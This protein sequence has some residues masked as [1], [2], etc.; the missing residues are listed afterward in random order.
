MNDN[1]LIN[2][3]I[4]IYTNLQ[5][6]QNAEN[7]EKEIENQIKIVKFKLESMG[8]VTTELTIE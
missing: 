3:L 8:I 5:R 7:K 2:N 4:D 6:I 1:E